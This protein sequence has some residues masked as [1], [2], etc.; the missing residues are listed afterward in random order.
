MVVTCADMSPRG[1]YRGLLLTRLKQGNVMLILADR[2]T[3]AQFLREDERIL[4]NPAVELVGANAGE[5]CMDACARAA[6]EL[7]MRGKSG[8]GKSGSKRAPLAGSPAVNVWQ[9]E[10]RHFQF[11]NNCEALARVFECEAGCGHQIGLEIPCYVSA[12]G[13]DSYQQCLVTDG[14]R[15][16]CE[17]RH[18][19]TERLCPCAPRTR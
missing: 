7:N 5:D 2:R 16:T 1:T 15:T 12:M 14:A 9:C 10:G 13:E 4:P 17:S 8:K 19:N 18:P 11:I 6:I 3:A